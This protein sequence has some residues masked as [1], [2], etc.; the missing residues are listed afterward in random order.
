MQWEE[1][2]K[3]W[4]TKCMTSLHYNSF[5]LLKFTGSSMFS[6]SVGLSRTHKIHT[7][8]QPYY[9]HSLKILLHDSGNSMALCVCVCAC[10]CVATEVN[11]CEH[12]TRQMDQCVCVGGLHM[13][14]CMCVC[15][16]WEP[17]LHVCSCIL[18]WSDD[19]HW[20][21]QAKHFPGIVQS[22]S[23]MWLRQ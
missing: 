5:S 6:T 19:W 12:R 17:S 9:Q 23:K 3:G 22:H 14:L 8:P 1:K 20:L 16:T 7:Q 2:E 18:M 15:L 4:E 13:P 10:M 21:S 11:S